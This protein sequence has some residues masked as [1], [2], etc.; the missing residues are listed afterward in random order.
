[1]HVDTQGHAVCL[2]DDVQQALALVVET[3]AP[4]AT[5][6]QR[7]AA[8][9][10]DLGEAS[11]ADFGVYL[12]MRETYEPPG[13][14]PADRRLRAGP[15]EAGEELTACALDLLVAQT[16]SHEGRCGLRPPSGRCRSA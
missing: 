13:E 16:G 12:G 9:A 8:R 4:E 7:M 15:G 10:L 11:D 5:I 14:V 1:M 2:G 3:V 6:R